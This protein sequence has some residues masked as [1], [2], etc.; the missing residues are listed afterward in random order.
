MNTLLVANPKGGSGK[1]TLATNLAGYLCNQNEQVV[2]WDLDRQR[3]ALNW[4]ELRHDK[5]P[6]I[7]SLNAKEDRPR[8]SDEG[9]LVLDSPAALHGKTLNRLVKLSQKVLVP[10]QPSLFDLHA[11]RDFLEK[12]LEAKAVKKQQAFVGM[13]G[14]RVDPRTRAAR[15]LEAFLREFDLPVL[16]YL[17]DTQLYVN[18]A[19]SGQS[20]F[21]LP[22]YQSM[23]DLKEWQPI[24]EWLA[25]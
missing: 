8:L 24:V 19:F 20:I 25:A 1:S 22:S 17:R 10:V 7:S 9:W 2:L 18:T 21:D 13:I 3:S 23:R 16:T 15:E 11:T 14:M 6:R 12:L 5:L 4:L